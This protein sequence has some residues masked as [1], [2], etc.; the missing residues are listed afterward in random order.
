MYEQGMYAQ[1]LLQFGE[2]CANLPAEVVQHIDEAKK[3][4]AG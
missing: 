3:Q 1:F 2:D 4:L